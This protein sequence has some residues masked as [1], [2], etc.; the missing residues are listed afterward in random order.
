MSEYALE[1]DPPRRTRLL[2][3]AEHIRTQNWTAIGIDF[4]IVVIGVFVGIQV[5]NWNQT[6]QEHAREAGF[7]SRLLE[8]FEGID[9][10]LTDNAVRW[11][12]NLDA[13]NR[14][15]ADLDVRGSTGQWPREK[16]ALL[17]DLNEIL[18]A[19]TPAQR[20][21]TYDEM[22]A[23][24]QLGILQDARLRD[25]LRTYDDRATAVAQYHPI[26]MARIDPFRPIVIGHLRFDRT[27][28]AESV[29]AM[30]DRKVA[31]GG[32]FIDVDLEALA[33]EPMLRQ[34]LTVYAQNFLDLLVMTRVQQRFAQP[35]LVKLRE[36][37]TND[38][39][40]AP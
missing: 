11:Q 9:A 24:G 31:R 3:L 2:R 10:R 38:G 25:A 40:P 35:V 6:R 19:R 29:I 14:L 17:E 18:S 7:A 12:S 28:T 27:L 33:A 30:L 13:A 15:L 26:L 34:A 16:A 39:G 23:D 37:G 4:V 8:D 21:A 20:S 5:A 32:Y 36:S 1:N 22:K